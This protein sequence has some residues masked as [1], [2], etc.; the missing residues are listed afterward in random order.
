MFTNEQS[1]SDDDILPTESTFFLGARVKSEKSQTSIQ[2]S[3]PKLTLQVMQ[4][5]MWLGIVFQLKDRE[6]KLFEITTDNS[7]P[8]SSN[9]DEE[10]TIALVHGDTSILLSDIVSRLLETTASLDVAVSFD[11]CLPSAELSISEKWI[12]F[13]DNVEFDNE[14]MQVPKF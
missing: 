12:D 3:T 8:D 2:Q 7:D 10:I 4:M 14:N 1:I 6:N 5:T 13:N 11:C 9:G